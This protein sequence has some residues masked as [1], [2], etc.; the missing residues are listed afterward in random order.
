M[1]PSMSEIIAT[2]NPGSSGGMPAPWNLGRRPDKLPYLLFIDGALTEGSTE[3]PPSLYGALCPALESRFASDQIGCFS[4][5]EPGYS[6]QPE[7]SVKDLLRGRPGDLIESYLAGVESKSVTLIAFSQSCSLVPIG[8]AEQPDCLNSVER[9][10]LIQPAYTLRAGFAAGIER[11]RRERKLSLSESL[12]QLRDAEEG[13]HPRL[14]SALQVVQRGTDMS[15]LVWDADPV[16]DFSEWT[17]LLAA[18]GITTLRVAPDRVR[19]VS[20]VAEPDLYL[21]DTN[22]ALAFGRHQK[23]PTFQ[24][25]QKAVLSLLGPVTPTSAQLSSDNE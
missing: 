12:M 6:Y 21:L 18:L 3:S 23:V 17:I 2:G 8:L 20:D 19:P 11:L 16:L 14:R 10:I 24:S 5:N 15:A 25:T 9:L 7:H 4:H 13:L 1:R 22:L